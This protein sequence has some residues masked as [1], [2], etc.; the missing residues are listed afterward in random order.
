MLE[1]NHPVMRR[2]TTEESI[3]HPHRCLD[4][5]TRNDYELIY[6]LDAIFIV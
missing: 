4:L 2:P 1:T 5:N 3:L 6:Q